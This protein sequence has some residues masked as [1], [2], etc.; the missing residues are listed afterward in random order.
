MHS[1]EEEKKWSIQ[2]INQPKTNCPQTILKKYISQLSVRQHGKTFRIRRTKREKQEQ[3]EKREHKKKMNIL[4]LESL[5]PIQ[6]ARMVTSEF[7]VSRQ[8][9]SR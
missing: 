6:I 7:D 8:E 2:I 9:W 4:F 5:F 3:T 1:T